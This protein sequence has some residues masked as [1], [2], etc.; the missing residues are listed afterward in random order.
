MVLKLHGS[1]SSTCSRRV[2]TV[3]HELGVEIE[4]VPVN[5]TAGENRTPEY[6][7]RQPFGQI[8][9]LDDDGFILFESRAIAKYLA[10][11][12]GKGMKLVPNP[13]DLQETALFDQAA[14]IEQADFDPFTSG[15]VG[16]RVFA[17]YRGAEPNEA[18][19]EQCKTMLKKKLEGYERIL[20]KQKYIAGNDLTVVDFFHLPYGTMCEDVFPDIYEGHT[21]F[22][23]WWN[24]LKARESWVKA[25][26]LAAA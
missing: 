24:E 11:K 21:N 9:Y 23:R 13:S 4:L 17:R 1:P 5:F 16:E 19:V 3:A 8:P 25:T 2:L 26:T 7:Q 18:R 6:L 10:N 22:L 14:S 15:I 12:Y 20:S